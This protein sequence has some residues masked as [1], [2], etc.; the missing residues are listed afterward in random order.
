[1]ITTTL[2]EAWD[3]YMEVMDDEYDS[4]RFV[5]TTV[6]NACFAAFGSHYNVDLSK[7][8]DKKYDELYDNLWW[9]F[10]SLDYEGIGNCSLDIYRE[11]VRGL[12]RYLIEAEYTNVDTV[13]INSKLH[14]TAMLLLQMYFFTPYFGEGQERTLNVLYDILSHFYDKTKEE[15]EKLSCD[16]FFNNEELKKEFDYENHEGFMNYHEAAAKLYDMFLTMLSASSNYKW[17]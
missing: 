6:R 3:L 1:M 5:E 16:L 12:F 10:D 8:I 9:G 17:D 2:E 7:V 11:I 13:E 4:E 15:I 14:N